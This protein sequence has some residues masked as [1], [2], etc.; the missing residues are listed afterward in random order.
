MQTFLRSS[1]AGLVATAVDIGVLSLCIRVFG[2]DAR[3]ASLPALLAGALVQFFGNRHWAFRAGEGCVKR[4]ALW[5]TLVEVVTL[6]LNAL[7]YDILVGPL[8]QSQIPPELTRALSTN[9]VFLVWSYPAWKWV[10]RTRP[11]QR[12]E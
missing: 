6:G 8:R 9:L 1:A 5:F 10:F 11:K 7:L 4:Q 3:L 12:K 2:M